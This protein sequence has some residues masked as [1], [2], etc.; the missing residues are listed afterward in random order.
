MFAYEQQ[1]QSSCPVKAPVEHRF[2]PYTDNGGTTL[3][4]AGDDFCVI[5]G[6]TRQ[7]EGYS[8]NTRYAPKVY[9]LSNGA[10]L[11]TGGMYADGVTLVKMI[12]QRLE[13]YRHAH[14]KEMSCGALAQML[15][16]ILYH[17]RM[18]PYYVWN[19]LGGLD[20]EGK[21]AVYSYDPVG[22]YEKHKWNCSGSAG[23]LVQPFLDNQIGF[24]HQREKPT[25][26]MERV[27]QVTK[28]AFTS[29]TERDIYTG[30][31]LEMFL[32][33]KEGIQKTLTDL[34]KD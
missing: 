18:F 31:Y 26:T 23:H 12:E 16:T 6:D 22:N 20:E 30:D 5:A 4:I 13:W 17:K 19:T 34:K 7:S 15:S 28:D 2:S 29:A 21:G 14:A 9:Q 10:V 8:I 1:Q 3:A 27:V 24:S 33:T 25:L 11:A 32:V